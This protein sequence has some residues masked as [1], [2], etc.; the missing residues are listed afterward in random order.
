MLKDSEIK[1]LVP[2]DRGSR[3]TYDHKRGDDPAKTVRGFGAR[4]TAAGARS[5]VLNYRFDGQERRLT[6]GAFPT[7]SAVQAREEARRL[8]REIDQGVDPLAQRAAEREAP[9][10]ARLAERYVEEHLPRKRPGSAR[11]DKAMLKGWIL[12]AL[13][14]KKV[15]SVRPADIEALHTKITKTGARTRANRVTALLSTMLS[16]AVRWEIVGRNVARGAVQ[17][18]PETK[19]RRYLQSDEIARLSTALA[20]AP[21]QDAAD[22]IRILSLTGAR[23]TEVLAATWGQFDL[24]AGTWSKPAESTKQKADHDTP[25]GAAVLEIL[26]R[27]KVTANSEYVFPSRDSKGY[28]NIR[29]TWETVRKTAGLEDVHLHDLRHSFASI[30][31]SGGASLPLIGALLGHANPST[32]A[33][34]AHLFMDPQR[35]AVERVGSIITG[36]EPADVVPLDRRARR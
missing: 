10:I 12:P 36:G 4:Q 29:T 31:V 17:R 32:T 1:A 11:D 3:I 35:A 27:R 24:K 6:I 22:A 33:R 16:L 28:L 34:Y 9:T 5:F 19:R 2:P 23:K 15:A 8:R 26:T 25:L 14:N 20:A 30:L 21:S 18:N 7:W 13:G